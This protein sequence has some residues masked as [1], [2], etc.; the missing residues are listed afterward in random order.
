MDITKVYDV[1]VSQLMN[2]NGFISEDNVR[3]YWFASILNQDNNLNNYSLEEPYNPNVPGGKEFDL[4]YDDGIERWCIEIKFH[5]NPYNQIFA[6][7]DSAGKMFD[8]MRRL[9]GWNG[10]DVNGKPTR[11]FFLYV[12]DDEMHR[13]LSN[14]SKRKGIYRRN[15]ADF[16]GLAVGAQFKGTFEFAP[17]GDTP[18]SFM[19]RAYYSAPFVLNRLD[20]SNIFLL[21]R[22][23]IHCP[24]KSMQKTQSNIN[25]HI[26]LYEIK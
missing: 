22:D 2:R 9:T 20:I 1:F 8:D 23:D 18:S 6:H 11:Y 24:S 15:L 13:Y 3:L 25:C 12:T 5:R 10:G 19:K 7:P 14:S 16:Y 17:N 4:M 26:R 21:K